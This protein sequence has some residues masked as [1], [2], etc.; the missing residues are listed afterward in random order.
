MSERPTAPVV[1]KTATQW[2]VQCP[3]CG[4]KHFHGPGEGHRSPHCY[5]R[6]WVKRERAILDAGEWENGYVVTDTGT[7]AG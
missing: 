1:R 5:L 2:T 7:T 6:K 3:Y 4:K